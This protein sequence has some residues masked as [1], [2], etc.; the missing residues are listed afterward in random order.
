MSRIGKKPIPIPDGVKV[1]VDG[2]TVKVEGPQG[3][4]AWTP[5]AEITVAVDTAA[6]TVVLTR[7]DDER[8]TR[9]LHGLSRTLIANMLEGCAKGYSKSLELYGVGYSVAV[10][11]QKFTLN[12]GFSHP[13]VF[14][15]PAGLTVQVTTPQA[16]GDTEPA[17]FTVR[18][19]DKQL[20]GEIA[21]RIRKARPPEPYKG[22]GVR[23]V[24]EHVR[25]KVGKAF[26]GAGT[27]T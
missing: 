25:R 15:L 26:A 3:K 12:C 9:S 1:A 18:G 6:K 21:A 10:Q 20:V 16:R 14:D 11:G 7:R 22:K 5:R 24:G 2:R 13:V 19:A 8:L 17:R 23:Y 4:L 27:A